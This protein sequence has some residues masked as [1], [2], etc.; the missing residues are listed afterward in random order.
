MTRISEEILYNYQQRKTIYAKEDFREFLKLELAKED[1][2]LTEEKDEG[3]SKTTNLVVGDP[4]SA[5]VLFTAHYDTPATFPLPNFI[6]PKNMVFYLLYIAAVLLVVFAFGISASLF[7]W[8]EFNPLISIAC[9]VILVGMMIF[10]RPSETTANENTSG[11]ITLIE[12]MSAMSAEQRAE[13][14]FVFFD[15]NFKGLAGSS[16]F[17]KKYGSKIEDKLVINFDCIGEGYNMMFI[18]GDGVSEQSAQLL[19]SSF[20]PMGKME[21][22]F[23]D[24][25]HA[26]YRSDQLRFKSGV[27]VVALR[28]S[29]ILG[30]FLDKIRTSKD[31]VFQKV[32]TQY[33][34]EGAINLVSKI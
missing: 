17:V 20:L 6:A 27:G 8:G 23:T 26:Y 2:I 30:Y 9:M 13:V 18:C 5:K 15:N 11:V 25:N 14:S 3:I 34:V 19:K 1:I 7:L 24:K 10:G 33:L 21:P 31:T 4:E 32:N 16:F 29:K 12:M 28:K 22:I